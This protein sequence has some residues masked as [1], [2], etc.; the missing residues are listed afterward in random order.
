MKL[1]IY[2]LPEISFVGGES[3]TFLFN[4]LTIAKNSFDAQGCEIGLAIIQYSNK[5]GMPV[6]TK[7]VDIFEGD[8]GVM[9][10]AKADLLPEDTIGLYG[11]YVY[12][13]TIKDSY[14]NTEIPGQG[15][16][17]VTRNIHPDFIT[18]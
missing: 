12:Q 18:G 16:M 17:H 10:I 14:N 11:R 7:A 6:L 15:I 2:T 5:N 8:S 3:Q 9:S 1:N 4:L 13:L